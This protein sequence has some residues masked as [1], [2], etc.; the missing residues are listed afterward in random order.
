MC[1]QTRK[2]G[3]DSERAEEAPEN[4]GKQER[5]WQLNNGE[6]KRRVW[7]NLLQE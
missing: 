4:S 2:S 5:G 3:R 6:N 7:C 1:L